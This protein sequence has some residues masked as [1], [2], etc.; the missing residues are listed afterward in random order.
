M[1]VQYSLHKNPQ[2]N[3]ILEK[4]SVLNH[5]LKSLLWLNFKLMLAMQLVDLQRG[6]KDTRI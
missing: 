2:L 6:Q 3:K 5:L 4:F 1:N